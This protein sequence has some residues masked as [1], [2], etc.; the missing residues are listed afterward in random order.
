MTRLSRMKALALDAKRNA[1]LNQLQFS[2]RRGVRCHVGRDVDE[3][4]PC[5]RRA[6]PKPCLALES[7]PETPRCIGRL[8]PRGL[9]METWL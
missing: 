1:N 7:C 6:V 5:G 4:M 8:R 2:V 9:S 3:G